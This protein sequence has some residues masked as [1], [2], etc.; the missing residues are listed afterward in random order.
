MSS[1]RKPWAIFWQDELRDGG[2]VWAVDRMEA[3]KIASKTGGVAAVTDEPQGGGYNIAYDNPEDRV[4][5]FGR[6]LNDTKPV[7]DTSMKP[8]GGEN[9]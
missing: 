8:D 2:V 5:F 6:D 9:Q 3:R 1:E 4:H 7:E